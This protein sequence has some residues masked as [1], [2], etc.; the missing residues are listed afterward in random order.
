MG[1][2][3]SLGICNHENVDLSVV[4]YIKNL[5]ASYLNAVGVRKTNSHCS[6]IVHV[7]LRSEREPVLIELAINEAFCIEIGNE[8]CVSSMS[9]R[10][11]EDIEKDPRGNST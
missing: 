7:P 11:C 1:E 10:L 6:G 5:A 3:V 4:D 8:N 9:P 2:M